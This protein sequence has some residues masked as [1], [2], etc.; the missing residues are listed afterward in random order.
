MREC[1]ITKNTL[2]VLADNYNHSS[3]LGEDKK[4]VRR[5]AHKFMDNVTKGDIHLSEHYKR[6]FEMAV[7]YDKSA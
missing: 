7:R 6:Y 2:T 4:A 3:V 5:V 1:K